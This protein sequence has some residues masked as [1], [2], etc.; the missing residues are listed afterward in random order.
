MTTGERIKKA[1]ID[2]GLTQDDLAKAL[3]TTKAAVSRL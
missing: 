2:R 3:R 1:R